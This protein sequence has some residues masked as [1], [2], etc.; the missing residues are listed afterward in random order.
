MGCTESS[1]GSTPAGDFDMENGKSRVVFDKVTGEIVESNDPRE[2]PEDAGLFEEVDAGQGEQFMAVKPWIGAIK[3]PLNHPPPN[4][5]PPDVNFTLD[6]VYGYRCEDSRQ[7]VYFNADGEA[8]YMTAA[9][10]VILNP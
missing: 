4:S 3:E 5:S 10:G 9:L 2:I 1:M 8:V 6:Y 7:N